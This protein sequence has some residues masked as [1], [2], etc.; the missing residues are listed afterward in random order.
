MGGLR[1]IAEQTSRTEAS[2]L[3]PTLRSL[4]DD[5]AALEDEFDDIDFDLQKQRLWVVTGAIELEDVPLGRF[6]IRLNWAQLG[7]SPYIVKALDPNLA[8]TDASVCHPHVCDRRLCEGEGKFAIRAALN[9]GRLFDFFVLIRQ[10]LETY[11]ESSAYVPLSSWTGVTCIDCGYA[12]ELDDS[13]SCEWCESD[14]C[15]EC[16]LN[17]SDC[18]RSCCGEC[19]VTCKGCDGDFCQSCL[20][21]CK[22]CRDSFCGEC[23]CDQFCQCCLEIPE[24][25]DETIHSQPTE[26]ERT[27]PPD[28]H[29]HTAGLVEAGAPA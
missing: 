29:V 16:V 22:S 1:D 8:G 15:S 2:V 7:N 13:S 4:V 26:A 23:L 27:A 28:T 14:L 25:N 11:N 9:E 12:S 10:V 3:R 24:D 5:L 17:C 6:E 19:R 18:G 21:S 20:N